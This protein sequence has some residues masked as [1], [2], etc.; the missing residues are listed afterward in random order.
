[1]QTS[2]IETYAR[3]LFD[4]LGP[5]SIAHAA[6]KATQAANDGDDDDAQKWRRIEEALLNLRGPRQS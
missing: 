1:M 2:E 5:K 4:Q 6:Q 3:Q